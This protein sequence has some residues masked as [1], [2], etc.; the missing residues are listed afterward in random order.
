M[1]GIIEI[2]NMHFGDDNEY[3]EIINEELIHS[4]N[5]TELIKSLQFNIDKP[6]LKFL[7][8]DVFNVNND[9]FSIYFLREI[10]KTYSLNVLKSFTY[11]SYYYENAPK[12]FNLQSEVKKLIYFLKIKLPSFLDSHKEYY[13]Y[14]IETFFNNILNK[15][16]IPFLFNYFLSYTDKDSFNNF[17]KFM[18]SYLD[19]EYFE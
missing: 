17:K 19:R 12:D 5:K 6:T 14:D 18:V 11:E 16:Q 3:Q 2:N 4:L 8:N 13:D 10:I 7:M 9:E 15:M 1:D